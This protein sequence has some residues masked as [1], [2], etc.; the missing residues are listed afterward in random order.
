MATTRIPF[1]VALAVLLVPFA[2]EAGGAE[3]REIC[4]AC[5]G[6]Q[7][8]YRCVIE[9]GSGPAPPA[10]RLACITTLAREGGHETCS[11][12]SASTAAGCDGP[13][14]R[15]ALPETSTAGQ[16][17]P[18]IAPP[19]IKPVEPAVKAPP[20]TVEELARQVTKSSGDQLKSTGSTLGEAARKTWG[21]VSSFFKS[22]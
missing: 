15:V 8:S 13:E 7:S 21:C 20:K 5:T 16:P 3:A 9:D 14:R 18:V 6:P 12:R 10:A 11:V 2:V 1:H 4:V 22:C 19:D 17:T